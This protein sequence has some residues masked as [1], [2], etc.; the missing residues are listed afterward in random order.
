MKEIIDV[1]NNNYTFA[2]LSHVNADGD[3][4]GSIMAIKQLLDSLNKRTYI[5]LQEP[6]SENYNFLGIAEYKNKFALSSYDVAICLDCPNIKRFGSWEREFHKSQ[7]SINIDHHPDNE[8]FADYNLVKSD[9]CSTCEIVYD[10]FTENN[11]EIIESIA[12]CLYSGIA[13][14]TGRFAHSNTTYSSYISAGNLV[15][16]GADIDSINYYLF[17]RKSNKEFELFKKALNNLEF[18]ENGKIVVAYITKAMLEEVGGSSNDTR[19]VV[20]FIRGIENV[21]IAAIITENKSLESLVSV[22]TNK[23]S[24]QNIC[25]AFGGGGH[26]KSAGCRIFTKF[27]DAKKKLIEECIKELKNDKWYN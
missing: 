10:L 27:E 3:A 23:S 9:K 17:Q 26:V 11:I 14:D 4:I 7:I 1:I 22:R 13:T 8:N 12:T 21:D 18:F 2:I 19:L 5:F 24:A 15:K 20:D 6:V 16:L 25:K